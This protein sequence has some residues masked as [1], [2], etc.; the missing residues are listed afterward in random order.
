MK[1][2][3]WQAVVV[4]GLALAAATW[5]PACGA[6]GAGDNSGW[7]AWNPADA[8]APSDGR[9]DWGAAEGGADADAAAEVDTWLPP[10]VEEPTDFHAPQGS[11]RFVFLSNPVGDNVVVIDSQRLTLELVEVGDTPT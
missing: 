2:I 3:P 1:R 11:S 8:D 10:E 4:T 5:Q 9:S 7:D 6:D